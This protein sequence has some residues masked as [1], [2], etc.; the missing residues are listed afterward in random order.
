MDLCCRFVH[1]GYCQVVQVL[2]QLNDLRA[3]SFADGFCANAA[4]RGAAVDDGCTA[5]GGNRTRHVGPT[6]SSCHPCTASKNGDSIA[7]V[8]PFVGVRQG[9]IPCAQRLSA[10][11]PGCTAGLHSFGDVQCLA[12]GHVRQ[13]CMCSRLQD[14]SDMATSFNCNYWFIVIVR[15][16][17][18]RE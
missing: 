6:R 1:P 16:T 9:S 8:G 14:F 15:Y 18:S 13:F 7:Q 12:H 5:S 3:L 17:K 10:V 11:L 4:I 2:I